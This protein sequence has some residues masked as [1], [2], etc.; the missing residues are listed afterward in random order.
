MNASKKQNIP[1]ILLW[2]LI[3]L[4]FILHNTYDLA[5]QFFGKAIQLP[6]AKGSIPLAAH[7]FK[8]IVELPI[9]VLAVISL[10]SQN[11]LFYQISFLWALLLCV[12]NGVHCIETLAKETTEISQ[13]A[14]LLLVFVVNLTLAHRLYAL[15]LPW[16]FLPKRL[17]EWK[18]ARH[19]QHWYGK[20]HLYLGLFAGTI[21]VVVGLTGSILVFQ[22]EIDSALNSQLFEVKAAQHKIPMAEMADMVRQKYPDRKF[23]Y[24]SIT[25]DD[26]PNSTYQFRDLDSGTEFF[27]NPYTGELC[28]KRLTNSSFIR[29]VMNIHMT[30]LIP[31]VGKYIVGFSAL[32]LLIL[33]ITG[34]RLWLP[35]N[36]RKWKQWKEALTVKFG[37]SFKRQN[38]DWHNVLG[39]YSAPV[40]VVLSLTG[41]VITFSSV[42]IGLMFMLNGKSPDALQQIFDNKSVYNP[43]YQRLSAKEVVAITG[44]SYRQATLESIAFPTDS[45]GTFMLLYKAPGT[46]K[47]GHL[48]MMAADQYTGE[49]VMNSNRDFPAVG[50]SYLN[51]TVPLHYGTFGGWPTRILACLGGLVPLAM[52]VTGFIIWWPRLKK[53]QISREKVLTA[54]QIA[55]AKAKIHEKRLQHLPLG[56]YCLHHTKKGLKYGVYLLICSVLC[57]ILYGA[58][59]GIVIAPA[60]YVM[61]YI[62]MAVLLNFIVA[63]L[64]LLFQTLILLPFGKSYRKVYKYAVWSGSIMLI[65][66]IVLVIV[67]NYLG[68]EFI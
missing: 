13:V 46:A 67:N 26:V 29:T 25:N 3:S 49:V 14:L 66:S 60:L 54:H 41:F 57:A 32:S 36:I 53:Q 6:D 19:Q 63:I 27:V 33:T 52:Y 18:W 62:G 34:I 1:I 51:W 59:S 17:R 43:T 11:K 4:G 8:I 35:A 58:L 12:L 21:L 64:C 65:F 61:Y 2:L 45:V 16:N 20:W 44:A 39:F 68:K 37:A 48:T 22:D 40:I 5:D 50:V 24:V 47:T 7:L 56:Q 42:F 23:N 38:L 15:C 31:Q 9:L 10:Y 30:L 28:G 55:K